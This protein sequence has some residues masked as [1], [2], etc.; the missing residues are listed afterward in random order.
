MFIFEVFQLL[1]KTNRTLNERKQQEEH[2]Q[3]EVEFEAIYQVE[4][5]FD[6]LL[7]TARRSVILQ[8]DASMGVDHLFV[9]KQLQWNAIEKVVG[10]EEEVFQPEMAT[11]IDQES[12]QENVGAFEGEPTSILLDAVKNQ[13]GICLKFMGIFI[14]KLNII[15][16]DE[17]LNIGIIVIGTGLFDQR[18]DWVVGRWLEDLWDFR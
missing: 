10:G 13:I 11:E 7:W 16:L 6:F 8:I 17:Q 5:F 3:E 18:L 12:K 4:I 2:A 1:E 14:F 15:L 9:E